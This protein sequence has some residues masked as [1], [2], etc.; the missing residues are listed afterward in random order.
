MGYHVAHYLAQQRDADSKTSSQIT[1]DAARWVNVVAAECS[2]SHVITGLQ[3]TTHQT[4]TPRGLAGGVMGVAC[5]GLDA[6]GADHAPQQFAPLARRAV[7]IALVRAVSCYEVGLSRLWNDKFW[8]SWSTPLDATKYA[9]WRVEV[10][11]LDKILPANSD[12]GWV[13]PLLTEGRPPPRES[14]VPTISQ[15]APGHTILPFD[16]DSEPRVRFDKLK[17]KRYGET[18]KARPRP[19]ELD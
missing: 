8:L 17:G 2:K 9:A 11:G 13:R 4:G 16:I 14:Q 1:Q 10:V 6:Y 15:A 18:A 3:L 7:V 12:N 19:P 5:S